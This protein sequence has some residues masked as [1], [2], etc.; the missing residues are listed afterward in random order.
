MAESTPLIHPSILKKRELQPLPGWTLTDDGY[1]TE[2]PHTQPCWDGLEKVIV[3]Q[4]DDDV[5]NIYK[6]DGNE[7]NR[8]TDTDFFDG[9]PAGAP[10]WWM[11]D[12]EID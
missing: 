12:V 9:H 3:A 10:A 7:Y 5:W 1:P 6:Y 2:Q 11:P 4:Q 8:L